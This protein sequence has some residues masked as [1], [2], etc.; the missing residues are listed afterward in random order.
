[1]GIWIVITCV[2][3]NNAHADDDVNASTNCDAQHSETELVLN[4]K[5]AFALSRGCRLARTE[6]RLYGTSP[7]AIE[8]CTRTTRYAL[9]DDKGLF[10]SHV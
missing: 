3:A 6:A 7:E 5:E 8:S 9:I 1:M 10:Q 2:L 4:R